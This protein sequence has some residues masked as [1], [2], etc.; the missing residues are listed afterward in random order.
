VR[1]AS[2]D[3]EEELYEHFK[4]EVPKGQASLRIDKYLMGLIQNATRNKIQAAATEG[5]IFCKRFDC[6]VDYKVKP[7]DVVRVMLTHPPYENHIVPEYSVEHCLR[8]ILC[9]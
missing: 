9:Y 2:S 8:M 5:N 4:F 3:L 1:A 6:E 7:F